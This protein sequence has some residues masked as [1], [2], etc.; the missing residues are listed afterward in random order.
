MDEPCKCNLW[1]G[2]HVPEARARGAHPAL[3]T[4]PNYVRTICID[5]LTS[6]CPSL[7][8][9]S[10]PRTCSI[11]VAP[12]AVRNK[13]LSVV[14]LLGV[15][16]SPGTSG[17]RWA[18]GPPQQTICQTVGGI[19][20]RERQHLALEC[21]EECVCG[22][23]LYRLLSFSMPVAKLG[24]RWAQ[25]SPTGDGLRPPPL[26][27][28]PPLPLQLPLRPPPPPPVSGLWRPPPVSASAS[29]AALRPIGP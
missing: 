26:P 29:A 23:H 6:P 7:I 8:T 9:W 10:R 4:Q 28:P 19:E 3:G 14:A 13:R 18:Q 2:R 17:P 5:F 11:L 24:P 21:P 27:P 22:K 1:K 15:H 12:L 25:A 16:H 20:T